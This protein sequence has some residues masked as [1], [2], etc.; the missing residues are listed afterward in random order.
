MNDKLAKAVRRIVRAAPDVPAEIQYLIHQRTGVIRVGRCQRGLYCN[1]KKRI[2]QG[3]LPK[4]NRFTFV[5]REAHAA[6]AGS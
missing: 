2:K 3:Q 4:L 6:R 5:T 1:L